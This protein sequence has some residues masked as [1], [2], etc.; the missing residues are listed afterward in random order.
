MFFS[1]LG[2]ERAGAPLL[3]LAA[4]GLYRLGHEELWKTA[5][6]SSII[7]LYRHG[8][9]LLAGAAAAAGG[10]WLPAVANV[11]WLSK[12]AEWKAE[13]KDD[14]RVRRWQFFS[15]LLGVAL[16]S[17]VRVPSPKL[18]FNWLTKLAR[19]NLRHIQSADSSS[20]SS[21]SWQIIKSPG[22][23]RRTTTLSWASKNGDLGWVV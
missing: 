10:S 3:H 11:T 23:D 12:I 14:A 21:T 18:L 22:R 13:K 20:S 16:L 9:R 19:E 2:R 5:R 7:S 15:I 17:P 8:I 4:G 1:L 6:E